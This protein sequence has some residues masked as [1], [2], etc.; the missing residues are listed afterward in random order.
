MIRI[1]MFHVELGAALLLRFEDERGA[2]VTVLA[3]AGAHGGGFAPDHVLRKLRAVM[4]AGEIRID[5]LIATHYDSDHLNL[6]VPVIEDANIVIAEAW[7]PPVADDTIAMAGDLPL[8]DEHILPLKFARSF[9]TQDAILRYLESKREAILEN[10]ELAAQISRAAGLG[11]DFQERSARSQCMQ[12]GEPRQR[13]AHL[14]KFFRAELSS[15]ETG[16]EKAVPDCRHLSDEHESDERAA[17]VWKMML[18]S[19]MGAAEAL[20]YVDTSDRSELYGYAR[21][22]R[23]AVHN[24][25]L[26]R[27]AVLRKSDAKGAINAA[28][29]NDVIVALKKRGV[30]VVS[31]RIDDGVPRL[32]AWDSAKAGFIEAAG[33]R[34]GGIA[35]ALLGPSTGLVRKHWAILPRKQ[36]L[37]FALFTAL[38]VISIT[39]SNQ[40][41]YVLHFRAEGQGIL[42]SGDAGCVDFKPA[43]RNAPYY[44][45]LLKALSP[46]NVVQVAHHGGANAHFFRV[47]QAGLDARIR[48]EAWYLLSHE[49]D[50]PSR[51]SHV[52]RLYIGNFRGPVDEARLLFTSAPRR[53]NVQ[54]YED[55]ISPQAGG[56]VD[57]GDISLAYDKRGWRVR[58][59]AVNADALT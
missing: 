28:A 56:Q 43:Q 8:D 29:L 23:M 52:F 50:S 36:K 35:F 4:G 12:E 55:L 47:L 51:P 40:L 10:R 11:D 16:L 14:I 32:F 7:L 59:H 26:Q 53:L 37:A 3:D 39:P 18:P 6:M 34:V 13:I 44:P 49:Q 2:P 1:D 25:G 38:P 24:S 20:D 31:R 9:E 46:L 54:G 19:W 57:F 5:L 27:L 42:V 21:A 33:G 15:T 22:S 48:R 45:D 17:P 58:A 30:P 41:S